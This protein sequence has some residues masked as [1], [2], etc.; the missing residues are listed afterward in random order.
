MVRGHSNGTLNLECPRKVGGVPIQNT[1][2]PFAE[3]FFH[4]VLEV[5]IPATL[6]TLVWLELL[7]F[8]RLDC[9]P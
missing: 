8:T 1:S 2:E 6:D 4:H 7:R 5:A 9:P 3:A